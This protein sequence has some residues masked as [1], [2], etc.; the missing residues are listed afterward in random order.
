MTKYIFNDAK[1]L[2]HNGKKTEKVSPFIL[3]INYLTMSKRSKERKNRLFL[4]N[5]Y[6]KKKSY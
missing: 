2:F 3:L 1:K 6:E 4:T 5:L